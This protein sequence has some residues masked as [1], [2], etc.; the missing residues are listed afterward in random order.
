MKVEAVGATLT[1]TVLFAGVNAN[2]DLDNAT[3]TL[4]PSATVIVLIDRV[5][6]PLLL[7]TSAPFVA[8]VNVMSPA[9]RSMSAPRVITS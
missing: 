9:A 1:A 4:A 8:P 3:F 2:P 6:V 7:S 5:Y